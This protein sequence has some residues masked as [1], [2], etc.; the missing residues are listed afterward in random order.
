M[1]PFG[2]RGALPDP[3]DAYVDHAMAAMDLTFD[4][5]DLHPER[6]VQAWTFVQLF[7]GTF[8]SST[9]RPDVNE[10]DENR[11]GNVSRR[12]ARRFLEIQAGVRRPDGKLLRNPDGRVCNLALFRQMDENGDDLVDKGEFESVTAAG[13]EFQQL[14][15]KGDTDQDGRISFNE[16]CRLPTRSQISPID[17]FRRLDQNLDARLDK[18]ELLE[19]VP[20]WQQPITA[21]VFPGFDTDSDERLS[22]DEYRMTMLAN[23][24]ARWQ[25]PL[26]D[27][28]GDQELTFAE[29]RF[30]TSDFPLLRW[31]YF[32]RLDTNRDGVLKVNEFSFRTRTPDEFFI[33][34]A[35]GTGW[36][37]LFRFETHFACGSPAVSPDGKQL[38]FDAWRVKPRT[39]PA[40]FILETGQSKPKKISSGSM[41]TWSAD[42]KRFACS[43]SGIRI[44]DVDGWNP[45][46]IRDNGWGAQWSPDGKSIAF[47][48]GSVVKSYDVERKTFRTILE[49]HDYRQILWNMTWS[50]DSRYLCLKGLKA[51]GTQEVV[52][53]DTF[54]EA[55]MPK[56]HYSTKADIN[57]DFAWHPDG[58]RIVFGMFC[59]ERQKTQLY[60]F[61]PNLDEPPTLFPGQDESRNNNDVCWTPGGEQLIVV[62]GDY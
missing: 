36:R 38:A 50:P 59:Q 51:G 29:F 12:E 58:D 4:A 28:D 47:T 30:D 35:D 26:S 10:A 19:G 15:K 45:M 8:G 53:L 44:L 57:A 56:V 20:E 5:W 17:E 61:N 34:N 62:S 7:I 33:V 23:P 13:A 39:S 48:E 9:T 40:L 3:L 22:L 41:P 55:P 49:S 16:W 43:Q 46:G 60:E 52:T 31:L 1:A 54:S 32:N 2:K 18:A 14:L 21:Y 11:D 6:Q 42:G 24:C 25:M 27:T 37:S